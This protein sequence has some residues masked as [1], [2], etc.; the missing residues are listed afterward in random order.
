MDI[1]ND[2][3]GTKY[4]CSISWNNYHGTFTLSQLSSAYEEYECIKINGNEYLDL[5]TFKLQYGNINKRLWVPFNSNHGLE[6][7]NKFNLKIDQ[8]N[9]L[10]NDI[11]E[12]ITEEMDASEFHKV[13]SINCAEVTVIPKDQLFISD[14]IYLS[15]HSEQCLSDISISGTRNI[16]MLGAVSQDKEN[17]YTFNPTSSKWEKVDITKDIETLK[18]TMFDI[19]GK[20]GYRQIF[21]IPMKKIYLAML[22]VI[23]NKNT[24]TPTQI[25][26]VQI[27]LEQNTQS[28]KQLFNFVKVG[29]TPSNGVKLIADRNVF[30]LQA[31]TIRYYWLEYNTS[32]EFCTKNKNMSNM[33]YD[34]YPSLIQ[35]KVSL[36]EEYNPHDEWKDLLEFSETG[37]LSAKEFW[38]INYP[39]LTDGIFL[40]SV[41]VDDKYIISRGSNTDIEQMYHTNNSEMMVGFRPQ[42]EVRYAKYVE[43]IPG[44]P[45]LPEVTELKDIR[46][47]TCISCDFIRSDKGPYGVNVFGLFTNLGKAT[48]PLL[49]DGR[50]M[51][52]ETNEIP[53]EPGSFYF[54]CIGYNNYGE[55][56][57]VPDRPLASAYK[58]ELYRGYINNII[59]ENRNTDFSFD[60]AEHRVYTL[61]GTAI[62]LKNITSSHTIGVDR[63]NV[64]DEYE[65]I[66]T[67]ELNTSLK[68]E[69]IWHHDKTY[70]ITRG[71]SY[72]EMDSPYYYIIYRD[73]HN[74]IYLNPYDQYAYT[75]NYMN[76]H[77]AWRP[78]IIIDKTP[79]VTSM[80]IDRC[81]VHYD[82]TEFNV[83]ITA[84]DEEF[85]PIEYAL[86]AYL[87][88]AKTIISDYSMDKERKINVTSSI[89]DIFYNYNTR[90]SVPIAVY[91][92]INGIERPISYFMVLID[93]FYKN[94][95]ISYMPIFGLHYDGIEFK[96]AFPAVYS[97][98]STFLKIVSGGPSKAEYKTDH[99]YKYID[100]P[101]N[102]HKVTV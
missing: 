72:K 1:I 78:I 28:S 67:N 37:G 34:V 70:T 100:I 89:K 92:K 9:D 47:G 66:F 13:I 44:K 82:D 2:P 75:T 27:R 45:Q 50:K 10:G 51:K 54:I 71:L 26:N 19:N 38:H 95:G 6:F 16:T 87:D 3:I 46:K 52:Y 83:N 85:N 35:S 14:A 53:V 65:H 39:S 62:R 15:Q 101:Y 64:F 80:R 12:E 40:D 99:G 102:L 79:R 25:N 88:P 43:C 21:A 73:H 97:A 48:L 33:F 57:L 58:E 98:D 11:I 42:I 90:G 91:A 7:T 30:Q 36:N 18:T 4:G 23:A 86:K 81:V 32:L 60:S 24:V 68:P 5:S 22:L 84:V 17:W 55:P 29:Y 49:T 94:V 76:K 61:D 31:S 74:N 69:E 96:N 8:T 77:M 63:S 41:E 59:E 56:M 93:P 20:S